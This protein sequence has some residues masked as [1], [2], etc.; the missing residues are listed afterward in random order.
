[1]LFKLESHLT[2]YKKLNEEIG[3]FPSSLLP[4]RLTLKVNTQLFLLNFCYLF[5]YFSLCKVEAND[6]QFKEKSILELFLKTRRKTP[7][8]D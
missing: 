7:R 5:S 6:K 2:Q 4:G 1:M 3:N 8:K